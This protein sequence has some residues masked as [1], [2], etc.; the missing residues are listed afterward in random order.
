MTPPIPA[1]LVSVAS[2]LTLMLLI[3]FLPSLLTVRQPYE[4][5]VR[6]ESFQNLEFESETESNTK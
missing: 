3:N 4:R 1:K 2:M 5:S 6:N